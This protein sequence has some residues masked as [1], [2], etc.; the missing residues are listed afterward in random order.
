MQPFKDRKEAGK[1]L[2]AQLMQYANRSD[3]VVVGLPRGGVPVAF[4][5]AQALHAPLDVIVTRKIGA[6]WQPELAVGALTQEGVPLF[7][8]EIMQQAGLTPD[9]VASITAEEQQETRRRLSLFRGNRPPL[10]LQGKTVIIVDD[11]VATGATMR[12]AIASAHALGA[13][14]VV[15]AL[16]VAPKEFR[17]SLQHDVDELVILY[18]ADFFPAVGYFYQQ[19]AQTEDSQVR[20]LLQLAD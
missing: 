8:K 10:D 15:V 12:A 17:A 16:P 2:A 1:R 18:E 13:H 4:E 7:N 9:A 19:F 5:V 20:A 6:P 11:G 14:T 3:V